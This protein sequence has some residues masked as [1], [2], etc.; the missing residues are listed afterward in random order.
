[1]LKLEC[2]TIQ[3]HAQQAQDSV[4]CYRKIFL[5]HI[6]SDIGEL[7]KLSILCLTSAW[8]NGI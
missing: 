5:V 1:M 7:A 8:Y 2:I 6:Y 3:N 4:N